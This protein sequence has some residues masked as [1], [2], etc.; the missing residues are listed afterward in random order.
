M[1]KIILGETEEPPLVRR[2]KN[3]LGRIALFCFWR[4]GGIAERDLHSSHYITTATFSRP[5]I[6]R[7]RC[8]IPFSNSG[9]SI[10]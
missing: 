2:I 7:N 8:L 6:G 5:L 10:K 3:V 4:G 9:S 1:E